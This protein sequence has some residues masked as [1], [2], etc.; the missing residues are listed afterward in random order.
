MQHPP[1][2]TQA[3]D[4][5]SPVW[6]L[7]CLNS[8]TVDPKYFP[9]AGLSRPHHQRE[10]ARA[11]IS[12]R[13]DLGT[14]PTR[15]G[16]T[17]QSRVRP[18]GLFVC[19]NRAHLR[20]FRGSALPQPR[21]M[22]SCAQSQDLHRGAGHESRVR[23]Q[24]MLDGKRVGAHVVAVKARRRRLQQHRR[25]PPQQ[26]DRAAGSAEVPTAWGGT[27]SVTSVI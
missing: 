27:G 8:L 15:P 2:L 19:H 25:R 16:S 11:A 24:H 22:T 20:G 12:R 9:G 18:L 5:A 23:S 3:R 6:S 4:C 13:L 21:R 1:S 26:P 14:A 10:R 17:R 7:S